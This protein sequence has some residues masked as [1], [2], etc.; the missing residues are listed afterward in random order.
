MREENQEIFL[1]AQ[2][3]RETGLS[4][5]DLQLLLTETQQKLL[6]LRTQIALGPV[7]P[8]LIKGYRKLIARIKTVINERCYP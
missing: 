6:S 2:A 3:I 5:S 8:H 1:S 4:N 7:R